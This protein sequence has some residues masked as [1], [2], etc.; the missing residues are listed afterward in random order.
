MRHASP[1]TVAVNLARAALVAAGGAV[2]LSSGVLAQQTATIYTRTVDQ[3]GKQLTVEIVAQDVHNLGAF[4]LVLSWDPAVVAFDRVTEA[5][6][7]G[8]TGRKPLCPDPVTAPN[9]I[10]FACVTLVTPKNAQG[11]PTT[12][13][14]ATPEA[15]PGVDG[16]GVLA[17]AQFTIVGSGNPVFHLSR[18]KIVDPVG[19]AIASTTR[20]ATS[21]RVGAG[22]SSSRRWLIIGAAGAAAALLLAAVAGVILLRRRQR[23][24][25]DA[26]GG[27]GPGDEAAGS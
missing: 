13:L 21:A 25:G 14:G 15:V 4:E 3:H 18:V 27:D 8:Q 7:L 11:T 6:F 19:G 23:P 24:D 20:D 1:R 10:R 22:G 17:R 16:T 26:P 2:L 5:G 9:A 12:G